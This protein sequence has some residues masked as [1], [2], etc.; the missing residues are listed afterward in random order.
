MLK[1]IENTLQSL[2]EM[3]L[4]A[5]VNSESILIVEDDT[6]L[7]ELIKL[8]GAKRGYQV[9]TACNGLAA[10]KVLEAGNIPHIIILDI[11]M[12]GM[13][14]F[15][16]C[17]WLREDYPL[18]PV[19]FLSARADEYDKIIALEIGGDDYLTKPFSMKELFARVNVSLRRVKL[20]S[21]CNH[22]HQVS[23]SIVLKDIKINTDYWTCE[24]K[25]KD[26]F[27]TISEFRIL[28]K[29]LTNPDIVIN[30]DKL[31]AAAFPDDNYNLGRSIDVHI[32]RIRRKLQSIDPGFDAIETIYQVGYKWKN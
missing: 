21:G 3:L 17:R 14:G 18:L 10:K 16:F 8:A 27:L 31:A 30:R 24:Y 23:S 2:Q 7:Q 5:M 15:S 32:C 11:N 1:F 12:P 25:G 13:D 6:D 20:Y 9:D 29:L 26:V 19:I 4:Y 22:L 28:H